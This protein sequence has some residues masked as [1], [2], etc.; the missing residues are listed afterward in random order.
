MEK[1]LNLI[2]QTE[3]EPKQSARFY[4]SGKYVKAYQPSKVIT[5]KN[6]I[7]S[8]ILEQLPRNFVPFQKAVEVEYKFIFAPLKSFSKKEL[9]RIENNELIYKATKT[10]ADNLEKS[11][12]DAMEK[13]VFYNDSQIAKHTTI[14]AFGKVPRTEII[15]KELN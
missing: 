7:Q 15:I 12:N 10:D 9:E 3:P 1:Q 6:T 14:K 4:Q 13:I 11:L 5:Y 2:I 8:M